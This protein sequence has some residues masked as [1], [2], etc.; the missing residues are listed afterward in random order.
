MQIESKTVIFWTERQS[1]SYPTTRRTIQLEGN[2]Q[3]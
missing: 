3:Q 1:T 2:K